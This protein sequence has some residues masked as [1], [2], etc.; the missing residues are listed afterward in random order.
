M[1][2]EIWPVVNAALQLGALLLVVS[3]VRMRD[4][5]RRGRVDRT[6]VAG[7]VLFGGGIAAAIL[8]T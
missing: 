1:H 7:A 8:G 4:D 3:S 2:L 6:T 5:R